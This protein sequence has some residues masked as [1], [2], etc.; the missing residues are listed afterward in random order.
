MSSCSPDESLKPLATVSMSEADYVSLGKR[1]Q[2]CGNAQAPLERLARKD[3]QEMAASIRPTEP[4]HSPALPGFVVE[5]ELGHG[6]MG[7]VYRAWQPS[8]RVTL[9]SSFCGEAPRPA[10]KT[11]RAGCGKLNP[12]H[13]SATAVLC[14]SFKSEKPTGGCI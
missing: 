9:R 8:L 7:V 6:S 1:I 14:R 4:Q 13:A 5:H 10:L 11:E 3:S 2:D 12:S